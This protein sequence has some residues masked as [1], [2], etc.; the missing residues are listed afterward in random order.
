[1]KKS[2]NP[3]LCTI[4]LSISFIV[5]G[6]AAKEVPVSVIEAENSMRLSADGLRY[7]SVEHDQ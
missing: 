5:G 4:I 7:E 1:M 3:F 2:H 6:C